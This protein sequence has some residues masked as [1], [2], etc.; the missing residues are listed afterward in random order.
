V[1][2]YA[3]AH[4]GR[5]PQD[6]VILQKILVVRNSPWQIIDLASS[7]DMSQSEISEALNGNKIA[8]LIDA[9]K[10]DIHQASLLEFLLY[11]LRCVFPQQPGAIVRGMPT[12]HSAPPLANHIVSDTEV[13]VWPD[14]EGSVRGQSIEPLYRTVPQAARR[15]RTLYEL[16]AL[17]DGLRVG[18]VRERSLAEKELRKRI[19][20]K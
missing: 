14:G 20:S 2:I 13:Y 3:P 15:D 10:K 7:L 11:G 16:L 5:R 18:K 19:L 9:G 17:V 4:I 1:K 12:A 8:G 6:I